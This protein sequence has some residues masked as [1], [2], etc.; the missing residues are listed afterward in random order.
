MGSVVD[1]MRSA[2]WTASEAVARRWRDFQDASRRTQIIGVVGSFLAVS[3]VVGV[4]VAAVGGDGGRRQ[5]RLTAAV[6][7]TADLPANLWSGWTERT[8]GGRPAVATPESA[9]SATPEQCVPGGALQGDVQTLAVSGGEWAGSDFTNIGLRARAETMLVA[10][11]RD[12]VTPVDKWVA[13]CGSTEVKTQEGSLTV[14]L[15]QLPV[16]PAVYHL[17]AARV[18]AQTVTPNVANAEAESTTLTAVGSTG[19]KILYV[20][21]TFP[22]AVTNDAVSTLDTLWRAQ[23]AKLVAYQRSGNL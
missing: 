3:V 20:T 19:T 7:T 6:V 17:S 23:S 12:V 22:G 14:A 4:V 18:F 21:L 2:W 9:M 13:A 8:M 5:E 15:T 11:D 16:K 1:R 10:S